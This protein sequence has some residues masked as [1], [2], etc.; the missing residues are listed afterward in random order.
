MRTVHDRGR[1]IR[2]LSNVFNSSKTPFLTHHCR[3]SFQKPM[4]PGV[5]HLSSPA[6]ALDR[7]WQW[8]GGGGLAVAFPENEL[9]ISRCWPPSSS[10]RCPVDSRQA[11][12]TIWIIYWT[13]S[14]SAIYADRLESGSRPSERNC[15]QLP[16]VI[17]VI[18]RL[19]VMSQVTGS[20]LRVPHLSVQGNKTPT[21]LRLKKKCINHLDDQAWLVTWFHSLPS[22]F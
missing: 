7:S 8:S 14:S 5:S 1:N 9:T 16:S 11:A 22:K 10:R 2:C 3:W 6:P 17:R 12:I 18:P 15:L 4:D 21:H 19:V 20:G 13:T